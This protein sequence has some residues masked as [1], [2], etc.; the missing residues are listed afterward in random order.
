[1]VGMIGFIKN[2]FSSSD[3]AA[4]EETADR[5]DSQDE[6][7]PE[8]IINGTDTE[9]GVATL[10][11][12]LKNW[13]ATYT[14]DYADFL[15]VEEAL[16]TYQRAQTGLKRLSPILENPDQFNT[17]SVEA[18]ETLKTEITQVCEFIEARES[19]NTEW[20]EVVKSDHN[21]ELNSY[22]HP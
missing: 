4:S 16:Q 21:D 1:M 7:D 3:T 13:Q 8:V 6:V 12:E 17:D 20:V 11:E 2:I 14:E 22:A 18:V 9:Q 15:T 19:Y 5:P 10:S